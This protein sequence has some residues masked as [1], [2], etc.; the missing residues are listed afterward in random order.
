V[1]PQQ[2]PILLDAAPQDEALQTM[3]NLQGSE[4]VQA[5]SLPEMLEREPSRLARH[6]HSFFQV[7][8]I[9]GHAGIEINGRESRVSSPS[10]ALI[11]P[12]SIH[13]LIPS[14]SFAGT[15]ISFSPAY[16]DQLLGE[17]GTFGSDLRQRRDFPVLRLDPGVACQMSETVATI[18]FEF[19]RSMARRDLLMRESLKLL[20]IRASRLMR[21]MD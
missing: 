1:T 21:E 16:F 8:L 9:S 17:M 12:A 3:G 15:S 10:L 13:R 19:N 18:Q 5:F 20:Q 4:E 6:Y 14:S 11:Y 7:M 2:P